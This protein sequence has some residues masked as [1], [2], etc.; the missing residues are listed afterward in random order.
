MSKPLS[1]AV[2]F[3]DFVLDVSAYELRRQG[4]SIR[5]E[6]RPMEL[7]ILLANR[8]GQLVTREEIVTHLWG[9]DVF[10]DIDASINTVIRKIRRALRDSAENS[11]FIQTIQGKGYRFIAAVEPVHSSAILAVLPFEN[12]QS[13]AD[14]EYIADGL[15]EETI[16]ELGQIDPEHLSVIGR[17]SSIAYRQSTKTLSEIARELGADYL[18]EGSVRG[19]GGQLRITV[20]LIRARDQL[21]VWT[22]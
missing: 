9:P 8:P 10:I 12:L 16:A 5:I 6:R 18:I 2:R 1:H 14:Q 13:D 19:A 11:R 4:R 3:D 21:Q 7:L 17:T 15:T 22:E 20:K